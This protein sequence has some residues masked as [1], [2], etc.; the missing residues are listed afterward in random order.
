MYDDLDDYY[1]DEGHDQEDLGAE[2]DYEFGCEVCGNTE[3]SNTDYHGSQMCDACI[4][5]DRDGD[6]EGHEER[7]RARIA[8][9]N[10]Y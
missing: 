5:M 8:E 2:L 9:Q 3:V 7:K 4:G 6:I 1:Y 10:E